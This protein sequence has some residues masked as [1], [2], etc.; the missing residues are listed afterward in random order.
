LGKLE[1]AISLNQSGKDENWRAA[2][3]SFE[4]KATKET[5]ESGKT[6]L[7]EFVK[8]LETYKRQKI[9]LR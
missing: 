5:D 6:F 2:Y 1:K 8:R 7:K 9:V 4:N 3:V